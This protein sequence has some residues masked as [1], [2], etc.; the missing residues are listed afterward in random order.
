[1]K[2]LH[3]NKGKTIAQT[4]ADRVDYADN[5]KKTEKGELVTGYG[6]DP[7]VADEQFL[8]AKKEYEYITGR[9]Q[10][11]KDVLAYHI[12]QAF[13]PGEVSPEEANQIGCELAARFF[14]GKHAYIVA[15]HTD[16]AHIH[17]HIVVNSTTLDCTHKFRDFKRSGMAVR[18]LSDL[19]CAE[20]GLSVIENPKPSKGKNYG[21]WLGDDKPPSWSEQIKQKVDELLPTCATFKDFI[22]ALRA[23]GCAVRDNR[24]NI[25]VTLPG[26]GR[27]IRLN[28]LG[29]EY[30]EEAIR[31][32]IAQYAAE[33][34]RGAR[35][36]G[37]GGGSSD[38][39][40][41]THQTQQ[42]LSGSV[43]L[44][45]DIQA[46]IREGKGAG[47]EQ[48][49]KVFNLKQAAKTLIFL[50]ENGIDSYEDLK[51]KASSASGGFSALNKKIR[52]AETRMSE[53]T[54]LQKFIG[55]YGKTRDVY[56]AY[57]KSGWSQKF[58][59]E[60]TAD[61]ILHRAAKS[62]FDKLGLKKLPSIN[63]LKQ[64]WAAL[65]A[66]KKSLYA[67][68]KQAKEISK[69]LTVALGNANYILGI[70]PETINRDASNETPR[71]DTQEI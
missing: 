34:K 1:M 6:C 11:A 14:K 21:K 39:G 8:L 65:A 29:G 36:T 43:S 2:S 18:R 22:A 15:T 32:R 57:K 37:T 19:L 69:S 24:K 54:E 38:S 23:A 51:K 10:G 4:L 61:I 53:I 49:A 35:S 66:E 67:G 55:Q 42:P 70:T 62:Y 5:P 33:I 41:I 20:H 3:V 44:L 64:E 25:S 59:D 16:K 28:T 13:K 68:F 56:A 30:S 58:Y 45:I 27:A 52:D 48:W 12:R 31:E 26:Q 7:P 47:Y 71:R 46:K 9:N 60:H 17:N 50:Q 40:T 63:Q